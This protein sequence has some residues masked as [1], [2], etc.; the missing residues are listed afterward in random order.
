MLQIA[1]GRS[2]V[3]LKPGANGRYT[4]VTAAPIPRGRRTCRRGRYVL[5]DYDVP[6]EL[7]ALADAVQNTYSQYGDLSAMRQPLKISFM[8]TLTLV[9]LLTMLAAIYGAIWSAQRLTR[10]VQGPDRR[11]ARGRQGRFRHAAAAALAR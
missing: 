1:A 10:P 11:H 5:I 4:I 3:S 6:Q 7:S 2:Y 8:L 9:V